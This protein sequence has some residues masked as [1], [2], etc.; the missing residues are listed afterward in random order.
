MPGH[1]S[2][3]ES[4]EELA[5]KAPCPSTDAAHAATSAN[6]QSAP[7]SDAVEPMCLGQAAPCH[8]LLIHGKGRLAWTE[9]LGKCVGISG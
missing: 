5:E 6:M 7:T 9:W 1:C 8:E 3:T 2:S 4:A